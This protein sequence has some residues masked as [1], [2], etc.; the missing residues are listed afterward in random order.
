MISLVGEKSIEQNTREDAK[1]L[2]SFLNGRGNRTAK[3]R[4][5]LGSLLGVVNYAYA[6]LEIDIR[7]PF[8]RILFVGEGLDCKQRGTFTNANDRLLNGYKHAIGT[9]SS[10]KLLMPILG[11]TGRRL[12]EVLG[13]QKKDICLTSNSLNIASNQMRRPKTRSG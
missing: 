10:V 6:E 13:L 12:G 7:N 5:R 3:I 1:L 11:E 4:R 9:E 2:V 8:S